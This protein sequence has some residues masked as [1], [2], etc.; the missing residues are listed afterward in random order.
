M[1]KEEK[2]IFADLAEEHGFI[3]EAN[4]LRKD[5]IWIF[6]PDGNPIYG[7]TNTFYFIRS[8]WTKEQLVSFM[9]YLMDKKENIMGATPMNNPVICGEII[10]SSTIDE[11]YIKNL[12]E[13]FRYSIES[14]L[15]FVVY[16]S[17]F[18]LYQKLEYLK[19]LQNE[20][21]IHISYK[22]RI[23]DAIYIVENIEYQQEFDK[24]QIKFK[25]EK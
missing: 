22:N 18:S 25:L 3:E 2:I 12:H 4:E 11:K 21:N 5:T 15:N 10:L 19:Y 23:N 6:S 9:Q 8:S 1:N 20:N 16:Q 13:I 14:I 24:K 7:E 17:D